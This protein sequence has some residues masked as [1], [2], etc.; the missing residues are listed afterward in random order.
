[1]PSYPWL[2]VSIIGYLVCWIIIA[3][4]YYLEHRYDTYNPKT[5]LGPT[6]GAMFAGAFW[7]A[8]LVYYFFRGITALVTM[9]TRAERR[10]K[11]V[12]QQAAIDAVRIASETR[13][14]RDTRELAKEF[15]LPTIEEA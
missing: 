7:W 15:G 9:P 4:I 11:R 6:V 2:I 12:R 3:R 14:A 5:D 13:V 1:M 10:A 8:M